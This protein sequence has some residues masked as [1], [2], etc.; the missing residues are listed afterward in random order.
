MQN[1]YA[2]ISYARRDLPA[3]RETKVWAGI[4]LLLIVAAAGCATVPKSR[5]DKAVAPSPEYPRVTV[6]FDE[7]RFIGSGDTRI[8]MPFDPSCPCSD[9][10]P[11]LAVLDTGAARVAFLHVGD[12]KE[13]LSVS[14]IYEILRTKNQSLAVEFLKTQNSEENKDNLLSVTKKFVEEN[15]LRGYISNALQTR[16]FEPLLMGDRAE[17]D[18]LGLCSTA[19]IIDGFAI[20][21]EKFPDDQDEEEI[22]L[23][24][25]SEF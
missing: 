11:I 12:T 13:A 10:G 19:Y 7:S 21:G 25:L 3:A 14:F 20:D 24:I 9:V 22:L 23:R 17:S 1:E 15:G 16:M 5:A 6:K 18:R 8:L 2:K 4:L